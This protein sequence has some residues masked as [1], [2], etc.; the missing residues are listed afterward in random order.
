MPRDRAGDEAHGG[1]ANVEVAV[2]HRHVIRRVP[3][4]VYSMLPHR[5]FYRHPRASE[6]GRHS[7]ASAKAEAS[8]EAYAGQYAEPYAEPYAEQYSWQLHHLHSSAAAGRCPASGP[9]RVWGPGGGAPARGARWLRQLHHLH[10][11]GHRPASG[12]GRVWGGGARPGELAGFDNSI[13]FTLRAAVHRLGVGW[14][15]AGSSPDSTTPSSTLCGSLSS[16][17]PGVGRRRAGS[18]EEPDLEQVLPSTRPSRSCRDLNHGRPYTGELRVAGFDD[19]IICALPQAAVR[20]PA[21][22]GCEAAARGELAGFEDFII[23]TLLA[24]VR[25]LAPAGCGAAAPARW[26]QE[27]GQNQ[28]IPPF[29]TFL[30]SDFFCSV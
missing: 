2:E 3:S 6:A 16:I 5:G 29:P 8:A 15:R 10:S 1:V 7:T 28:Y 21:P 9:G 20:H 25:H 19:F 26:A 17:R 18:M 11:A 4:V 23:C 30:F 27:L 24:A 14:R 22:A 12:S 13:I